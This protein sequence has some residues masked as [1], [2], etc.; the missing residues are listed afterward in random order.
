MSGELYGDEK[1]NYMY[2]LEMDILRNSSYKDLCVLRGA[3]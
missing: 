2:I 3:L 1:I